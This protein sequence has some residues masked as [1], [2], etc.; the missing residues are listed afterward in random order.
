[1]SSPAWGAAPTS[2]IVDQFSA[3]IQSE[4]TTFD[5]ANHYGNANEAAIV[6]IACG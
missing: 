4:F 2:K 1:M 3:H 6:R 5:M